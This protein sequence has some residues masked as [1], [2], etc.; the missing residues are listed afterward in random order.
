[1]W[2]SV[3]TGTSRKD[4]EVKAVDEG[5][6]VEAA[7]DTMVDGDLDLDGQKAV[8]TTCLWRERGERVRVWSVREVL[9][10]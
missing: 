7:T 4:L 5:R 1:M 9:L 10:V 8:G 6:R 2:V 3:K